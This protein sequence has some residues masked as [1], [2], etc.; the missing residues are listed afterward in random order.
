MFGLPLTYY[1][2]ANKNSPDSL[3]KDK[4]QIIN[5][6]GEMIADLCR[7]GVVMIGETK[8]GIRRSE[9]GTRSI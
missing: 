5:V 8:L 1:K 9:I 4:S 7:N 6:T 3:V 2:G